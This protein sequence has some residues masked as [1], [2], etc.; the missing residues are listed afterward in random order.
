MDER[1]EEGSRDERSEEVVGGPE[2]DIIEVDRLSWRGRGH[3][4]D[5]QTHC[6]QLS[7]CVLIC[8]SVTVSL[9]H[10]FPLHQHL[11]RLFLASRL[12]YAAFSLSLNHPLGLRLRD[13]LRIHCLH[14]GLIGPG[15]L[16]S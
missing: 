13:K 15:L 1:R 2:L 11:Y 9:D 7:R 6:F 5:L 4:T 10:R 8:P 12:V 16:R 14:A 3:I